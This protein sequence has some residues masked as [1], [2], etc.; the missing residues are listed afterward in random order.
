M[1]PMTFLTSS[2]I[3]SSNVFLI[4]FPALS[5]APYTALDYTQKDLSTGCQLNTCNLDSGAGSATFS[6]RP[7]CGCVTR[8]VNA[9][10][11]RSCQPWCDVRGLASGCRKPHRGQAVRADTCRD[12]W[13]LYWHA[14][15]RQTH[16]DIW[17]SEQGPQS[18]SWGSKRES[19]LNPKVLGE[20]INHPLLAWA[21][22]PPVLEIEIW[23]FHRRDLHKNESA[24]QSQWFQAVQCQ[25]AHLEPWQN[26]TW[27]Q[28]TSPKPGHAL[29]SPQVLRNIG[30]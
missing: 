10:T 7:R 13:V 12:G 23:D 25:R 29:H 4:F 9:T 20:S 17:K 2:P 26:S 15:G 19:H 21:T 16:K 22:A 14:A 3:R 27:G 28:V 11:R 8:Q 24:G 6:R 1:T 18:N 5:C 30:E